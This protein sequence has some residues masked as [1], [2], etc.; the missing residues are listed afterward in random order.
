VA[1]TARWRRWLAALACC[2]GATAADEQQIDAARSSMGF[3]LRTRWGQRV[4]GQF[5]KHQGEVTALADGR[6]QVQLTLSAAAIEV[7]G[8]EYYTVMARGPQFFDAARYPYIDFLSEP[9]RL[10]LVHDGGALR[11]K[12][13]LHGVTRTESFILQP[14]ECA[15]PGQDCDVVAT[16][17][18]D[19]TDY[20]LNSY[21]LAL[22]DR[23]RFTMRV[24]LK[25]ED[26]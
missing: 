15:R 24:R 12:L 17:T 4:A 6:Q 8:S 10:A 13:T 23:V 26:E 5:T 25:N 20:G 19:R 14:A 11:G 3:E 9:H 21:R 16:G 1:V 22:L 18:I 2:A 7:A